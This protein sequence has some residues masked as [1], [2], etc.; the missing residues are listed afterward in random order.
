MSPIHFIIFGR[1]R[2][3]KFANLR[4]PLTK[5][6]TEYRRGGKAPWTRPVRGHGFDSQTCS[7]PQEDGALSFSTCAGAGGGAIMDV[8]TG[9]E[10]VQ[11]AR[12]ARPDLRRRR[13]AEYRFTIPAQYKVP[14]VYSQ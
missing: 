2:L 4:E 5:M 3:E 11:S 13:G 6:T 1:G 14:D 12:H 10:A 7:K 8:R 9:P